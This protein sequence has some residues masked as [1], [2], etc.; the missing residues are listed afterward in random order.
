MGTSAVRKILALALTPLV[1]PGFLL[2]HTP[3]S[4][5]AFAHLHPHGLD[6]L[7][8]VVVVGLVAA[9]LWRSRRC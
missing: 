4:E 5:A 7:L 2:A 3:G 8:G 1:A 6:H 9:L